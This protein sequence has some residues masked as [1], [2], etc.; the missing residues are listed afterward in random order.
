MPLF[1]DL[2]ITILL[3]ATMKSS[4]IIERNNCPSLTIVTHS[5]KKKPFSDEKRFGKMDKSGY[6]FFY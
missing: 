5:V 3:S 6:N 4:L 2:L 1:V